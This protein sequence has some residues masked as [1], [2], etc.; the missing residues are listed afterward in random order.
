MQLKLSF[1][2]W[3]TFYNNEVK[4][5]RD[6]YPGTP[7]LP[8]WECYSVPYLE[9]GAP[10]PRPANLNLNQLYGWVLPFTVDPPTTKSTAL[11][12]IR[13]AIQNSSNHCWSLFHRWRSYLDHYTWT[14]RQTYWQVDNI[15]STLGLPSGHHYSSFSCL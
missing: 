2:L 1:I 12:D 11:H 8:A 5:G 10:A 6:H 15:A 14:N 9:G 7:A 13:R 3:V 4:L